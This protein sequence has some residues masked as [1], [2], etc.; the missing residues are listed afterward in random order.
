VTAIARRAAAAL[1]LIASAAPALGAFLLLAA[2][3]P[4]AAVETFS[5]ADLMKGTK[6]S[7]EA[8]A[9][10]PHSVYVETMGEGVCIRY[11]VGGEPKGAT[12]AVFFPGDAF[13]FDAK[14][15]IAPD[16]G[17]LTQA[18]E[19][20]DAAV[21]VW[22]RRLGVPVVFFGRLGMHGSSGWHGDRRTVFEVA[23]T[24]AALDR[25]KAREGI[26]G[27]HPVGQSGG[28]ILAAAAVAARDDIRCAAIASTPLDFAAFAKRFGI[29]VRRDGRR[30]HY[31]SMKDVVAFAASKARVI[32]LTDPTDKAVP[33]PTQ[34]AFTDAVKAAGGSF[35]HLFTGGRGPDHHALT[36]KAMFS[37][38][39]CVAGKS[40]EEIKARYDG[41][42]PDDLPPP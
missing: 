4:A 32:F 3:G 18:P 1:A 26:T 27:W 7:A 13:G 41:T 12:T 14:G 30:A 2:A 31:D 25:I 20:V 22:S 38:A 39:L 17:Y 24:L 33:P 8:C 23:V 16:P 19:Y 9:A 21:R 6:V 10:L 5:G 35:L 34:T 37:T 36:E 11:Y 15:K 28:G 42:K 40:D 29:T